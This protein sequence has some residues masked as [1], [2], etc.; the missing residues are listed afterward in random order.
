MG[1]ERDSGMARSRSTTPRR[2]AIW[3]GRSLLALI[4]ASLAVT[5]NLMVAIHRQALNLPGPLDSETQN[6][7]TGSPPSPSKSVVRSQVTAGDSGGIKP[8]IAQKPPDPPKAQPPPE[9]PTEKAVAGLKNATGR[10]ID[11]SQRSDRRAATLET[12]RQAS[13]AESRRW[14]RRELLVRQQIAGL[15][16]RANQL[17]SDADSLDAERDVLAR[18]RDSLKAALTKASRRSGFAVLP[19]KGPNGT[20][21]R[22]IVLECT[23][24]SVKL[25]PQGIAFSSMDLSPLV[26]PRSSPLVRAVAR[27]ML[28]VQAAD[29]PD[30]APAVPYL[31]FLVRPSG[32]RPYYEARTCLEP[33]GIAFGYELIEQD[34]TVDIPDFDKLVTWDGSVPLDIPL[35][36]APRRTA[37]VAAN[38]R[39]TRGTGTSAGSRSDSQANRPS[40]GAWPDGPD[41][42]GHAS[43]GDQ[44]NR[45]SDNPEDFVWPTRGRQNAGGASASAGSDS[46][47]GSFNREDVGHLAPGAGGSPIGFPPSSSGTGALGNRRLSSTGNF[48][49]GDR[50]GSLTTRSGGP[51]NSDASGGTAGGNGSSFG[52]AGETGSISNSIA[53]DGGRTPALASSPGSESGLTG[54]GGLNALPDLEPIGDGDSSRTAQSQFA[55][56]PGGIPDGG[57]DQ[58]GPLES[59]GPG[60]VG[61]GAASR[62]GSGSAPSTA[63]SGSV[64]GAGSFVQGRD[65]ATGDPS[66]EPYSGQSTGSPRARLDQ[67][68][69]EVAAVWTRMIVKPVGS[70]V[71]RSLQVRRRCRDSFR[72]RRRA[73]QRRRRAFR[74]HRLKC[75]SS[76]ARRSHRL[77][78]REVSP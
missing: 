62:M 10:E 14:K 38:S 5:L 6:T 75:R 61:I 45:D 21:R 23:A 35:E 3:T 12:A 28:H 77:V 72:R 53:R 73:F 34:L 8:A 29:T 27:E 22:P 59:A 42:G 25:Q 32:I 60:Q 48:G 37:A 19:Y 69:R 33:L 24:G 76:P 13:V 65:S 55:A 64:G 68:V 52:S 15:T 78:R 54:S 30:G 71:V 1:D 4:V 40:Y 50:A 11:E 17:E 18:E 56:S 26:N 47:A 9:D 63:G 70:R 44:A 20:W 66:A 74:R 49:A 16:D 36:T 58:G 46:A 51:G 41:R 39:S 31:V 7:Q 67:R 43:S 2:G 57:R